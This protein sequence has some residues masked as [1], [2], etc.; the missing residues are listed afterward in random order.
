MG[1][2][3]EII[4]ERERY[5]ELSFQY[6]KKINQ[7]NLL[8]KQLEDQIQIVQEKTRERMT[9]LK[10]NESRILEAGKKEEQSDNITILKE[11]LNVLC[12]QTNSYVSLYQKKKEN[13]KKGLKIVKEAFEERLKEIYTIGD[14][15]DKR[16]KRS[17][18]MPFLFFKEEEEDFEEDFEEINDVEIIGEDD[19]QSH[20]DD[21]EKKNNIEI[22]E[23][24][25]SEKLSQT[26]I[27]ETTRKPP[28]SLLMFATNYLT[29]KKNLH[30]AEGN[31]FIKSQEKYDG[32]GII[33]LDCP[34]Y[35]CYFMGRPQ[36]HFVCTTQN[37]PLLLSLTTINDQMAPP[38]K[39]GGVMAIYRSKQQE[40]KKIIPFGLI[41]KTEKQ[42]TV[43]QLKSIVPIVLQSMEI[44]IKQQFKPFKKAKLDIE[45]KNYETSQ[46]GIDYKFGLLYCKKGQTTEQEMYDNTE[47]NNISNEYNDFIKLIGN[48]IELKGHKGFRAGLD[49]NSN[50]TGIKSVYTMFYSS[51][52]MFHVA[53]MLPHV[54]QDEQK[55]EKKRHIG[56]DFCVL[57]YKEGDEIVDL[58]SFKSHF[59][60]IFVIVKKIP[61]ELIIDHS[62]QYLVETWR[63]NDVPEFEP[64]LPIEGSYIPKEFIREYLLSTMINGQIA[65]YSG[66]EMKPKMVQAR[67]ICLK[68]IVSTK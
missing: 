21:N 55:T 65:S 62:T 15:I 5:K 14:D 58:N 49:V 59:N 35:I 57:I 44:N 18:S 16:I 4:K 50:T 26:K 29:E 43:N 46:G 36:A 1:S 53:T 12:K 37:G 68:N 61:S 2:V 8:I 56:N 45:L 52:I 30:L 54:I 42:I 64:Y 60:S 31:A 33:P 41:G 34:W 48:I 25:Q 11:E 38:G 47:D 3:E 51:E 13:Y 32:V 28:H 19:E 6:K 20:E 39:K 17:K 23:I 22:T 40:I 24:N 27:I 67:D 9:Q 66:S 7:L 63:G 10:A